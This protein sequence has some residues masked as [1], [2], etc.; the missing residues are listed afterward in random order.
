MRVGC[1]RLMHAL[2]VQPGLVILVST[3]IDVLQ[4][5]LVDRPGS[6]TMVQ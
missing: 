3:G 1:I 4:P 5:D 6:C 2:A